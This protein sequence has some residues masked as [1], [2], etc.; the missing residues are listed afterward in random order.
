MLSRESVCAFCL[1]VLLDIRK[2]DSESL[3]SNG[4]G[5]YARILGFRKESS[6]LLH[7][8]KKCSSIPMISKLADSVKELDGIALSMLEK[9]IQAA[10][11][12]ESVVADKFGQEFKNEFQRQLVIV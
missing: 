4:F 5:Q 11:I 6:V 10:H 3:K 8:I 9:D 2:A 7:E 12:Y 1:N